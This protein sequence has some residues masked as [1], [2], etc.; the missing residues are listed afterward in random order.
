MYP[1][2]RTL[3][4]PARLFRL[5]RMARARALLW[6]GRQIALDARLVKCC[7]CNRVETCRN[8]N[9]IRKNQSCV[10]RKVLLYMRIQ[11]KID[12]RQ[13]IMRG[14]LVRQPRGCNAD[15]FK[16]RAQPGIPVGFFYLRKQLMQGKPTM[17]PR[18]LLYP[19]D[20]AAE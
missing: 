16:K 17:L 8:H 5:T 12:P 2:L 18:C 1:L 4:W 9:I 20:A 3:T 10:V 15:L 11:R 14:K 7:G 6:R 13:Q 19:S